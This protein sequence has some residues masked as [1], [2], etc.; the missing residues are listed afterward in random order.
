MA[1]TAIENFTEKVSPILTD[2]LTVVNSPGGTPASRKVQIGNILPLLTINSVTINVFT[3]NATYTTPSN[4]KAVLIIAIGGGG[5]GAG[6]INT[7]SS[8]GGGGAGGAAIKLVHAAALGS[9]QTVTVGLGGAA[10]TAGSNSS[11]GVIVLATGGSPG[12]AGTTATTIGTGMAAG[13]A[14]GVGSNASLNIVGEAGGRSVQISG[15]N[16]IAGQGGS[17]IW[18]GGG[19]PGG[20]N[21]AG[22]P[23]NLYGGGGGGG[24]ASATADRAGGAGAN[25]VVVFIEFRST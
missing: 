23:G 1:N 21:L 22:N 11:V 15:S 25:G 6:G 3:S 14:G 12:T 20:T 5:G 19:D 18:G 16:G 24:H 13:G 10:T 9:A 17:S 8:G 4:V 7:D 2:L